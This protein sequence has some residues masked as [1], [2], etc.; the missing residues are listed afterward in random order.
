[1]TAHST[2]SDV[3]S[4]GTFLLAKDLDLSCVSC[5]YKVEELQCLPCLHSV[6]VCEKKECRHK[7]LTHKVSCSQC[8]EVF[9][10][11][12]DG[13]PCHSFA[14]RNAVRKERAEDTVTFC[15]AEH[16]PPQL[17][18]VYCCT[19]PGPLCEECRSAHQNV[20]LLK[21]HKTS[22]LDAFHKR[23]S[24]S[25]IP[26]CPT[27]GEFLHLYCVSCN[28][29]ICSV[30]NAANPHNC[31]PVLVVNEELGIKN[32]RTLRACVSSSM[33][34]LDN[35]NAAMEEI[36]R[37]AENIDRHYMISKIEVNRTIDELIEGLKLRRDTLVAD[38]D[39]ANMKRRR[40][41][42]HHKEYLQLHRVK[43]T[44][45]RTAAEGIIENASI[46]E[47]ITLSQVAVN[48]LCKLLTG[49]SSCQAPSPPIVQYCNI[50]SETK[51]RI[52]EAVKTLGTVDSVSPQ[53]STMEGLITSVPNNVVICRPL[54]KIPLSFKV[55]TKDSSGNQCVFGGE[56]VRAVLTPTA[57]GVPVSGQ[58]EDK[59]DG[60]YG[61]EFNCVPSNRCELVVTV[62]G[63]HIKGS[64]VK[65]TIGYPPLSIRQEI[66]DHKQKRTFRALAFSRK[67]LL[68]ATDS[69]NKE[70]CI[71]NE[72]AEFSHSFKVD[73][74]E[75]CQLNGIV[76]LSDGVIAVSLKNHIGIYTPKGE[77][78]KHFGSSR[79]KMPSGLAV[80]SKGQLF[81]ADNNGN[82][83][84]IFNV[85]QSFQ[86]SFELSEYPHGVPDNPA[87][88]YIG[89]DGLVYVCDGNS[90][91]VIVLRQDGCFL[92]QFG[93][94]VLST[95]RG[96]ALTKYGDA[97]VVTSSIWYANSIIIFNP[98]GSIAF[99]SE[100]LGLRYPFG[101]AINDGGFIFVADSGNGRIVKI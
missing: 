56:N 96:I 21:R 80:N 65:V 18:V 42:E 66:K 70:I 60:T 74:A 71:F 29:L 101:V 98:Y 88:I 17:A 53:N 95:P 31:D 49:L 64:P 85:D 30:C 93:K 63:D 6:S 76:E 67:G 58:V 62:N 35:L 100:N 11:P 79:L 52:A 15:C 68:L 10:V 87:Q 51:V 82:R 32:K 61:V 13:F 73:D 19:C 45:Y 41:L 94:N 91:C 78:I 99:G 7:M 90:N 50:N 72:Q 89:Q 77:F 33:R 23:P 9:D 4:E 3:I 27:H 44:A 54:S 97:V 2:E 26:L 24:T 12:V 5:G 34:E 59:G 36:D 46:Q 20:V 75:D 48:R 1:M 43:L 86:T 40:E 16:D 83:V 37:R 92:R 57:C 38:L 25:E 39:K 14:G 55:V 81:V 28:V 47:Q 69:K 84:S 22:S 8:Q